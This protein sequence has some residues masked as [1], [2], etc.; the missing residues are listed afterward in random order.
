VVSIYKEQGFE[1]IIKD[2]LSKERLLWMKN[3]RRLCRN[4]ELTF[5]SAEVMVK[6]LVV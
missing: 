2:G 3:D 5:E 6:I 1:L 4:K